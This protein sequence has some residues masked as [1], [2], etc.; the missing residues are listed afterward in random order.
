MG[1]W[2]WLGQAPRLV[3]VP[4]HSYYYY[5][6]RLIMFTSCWPFLVQHMIAS[7]H[8]LPASE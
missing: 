3:Y 6:P 1:L 2:E 7:H 4:K 5:R 8:P